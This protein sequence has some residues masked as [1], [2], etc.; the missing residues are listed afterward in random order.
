MSGAKSDTGDSHML[1]DMVRTDSHQLR[2]VACDSP[3]VGAVKVVART[4]GR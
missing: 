1:A 3:V 4:R 2:T